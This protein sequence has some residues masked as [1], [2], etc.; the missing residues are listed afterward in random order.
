VIDSLAE[1]LA[2]IAGQTVYVQLR[3]RLGLSEAPSAE[4]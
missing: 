2:G 3:S 4:T 1:E